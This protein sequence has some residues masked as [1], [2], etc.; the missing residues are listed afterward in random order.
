VRW[1]VENDIGAAGLPVEAWA[2]AAQGRLEADPTVVSAKI[3]ASRDEDGID[4]VATAD[5]SVN[6]SLESDAS[7]SA[8]ALVCRSTTR[9]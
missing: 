2:A 9:T 8:A 4:G 7:D 1:T 3:V 6:V 5:L